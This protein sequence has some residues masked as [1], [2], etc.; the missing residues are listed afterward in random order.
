MSSI[1][2]KGIGERDGAQVV[3]VQEIY[4]LLK[5]ETMEGGADLKG[6][7]DFPESQRKEFSGQVDLQGHNPP[8]HPSKHFLMG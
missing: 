5:R 6:P 1:V 8:P 3:C 7:R 2:P 4:V